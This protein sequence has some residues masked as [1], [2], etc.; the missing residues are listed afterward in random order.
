MIKRLQNRIA[1]SKLALPVT[2]V[3]AAGIWL[4]CGLIDKEWWVQFGCFALS[5]YLMVELNNINALIRIYSRMVSC[6][7]LML[8]CCACFLFPSIQGI[9]VQAFVI[10]VFLLLFLTYQKPQA[11]GIIYYAFMLWGITTMVSVHLLFYLPLLWLLMATNLQSLTWRTCGAS[12]LGFL[13]P[14]WVGCCWLIW[15]GDFT[16][17]ISHFEQL[18]DFQKPLQF[19]MLSVGQIAVY[20]FLLLLTIIGTVHFIRQQHNDKIRI[21]QLYGV[22][23]WMNLATALMLA[24]Q[25]QHYDFLIRMMF[26]CTAPVIGHFLALTHT[27]L[28][29]IAFF[30]LVIIT[31]VITGYNLWMSS[32]LF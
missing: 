31:L 25:P 11:V 14:Y 9:L 1:E 17:L 23:I 6:S 2:A 10:G 32:Y 27:K 5:A 28:T 30:L 3:Y 4:I 18:A 19:A 12:I 13:T 16:P 21:R 24:L 8:T 22:F 7:F 15:Q 20:V 26:V 29:N